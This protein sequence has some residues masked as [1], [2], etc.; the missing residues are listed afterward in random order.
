[1]PVPLPAAAVESPHWVL[2][3]REIQPDALRRRHAL[4]TESGRLV[5]GSIL[6]YSCTLGLGAAAQGEPSMNRRS[7]SFLSSKTAASGIVLIPRG[8]AVP[9]MPKCRQLLKAWQRTRRLDALYR[10]APREEE[11][12]GHP[13]C[14]VDAAQARACPPPGHLVRQRRE[15]APAGRGPRMPHALSDYRNAS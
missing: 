10:S 1:M 13:S 11:R 6:R 2:V 5:G 7:R 15:D 3:S 8:L 14:R 12:S 4:L 9:L